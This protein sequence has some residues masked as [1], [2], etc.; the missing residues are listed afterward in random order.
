MIVTK[1]ATF[2]DNRCNARS[3]TTNWQIL[4]RIYTLPI[5]T[6]TLSVLGSLV[7]RHFCLSLCDCTSVVLCISTC[8]FLYICICVCHLVF[9]ANCVIYQLMD[10]KHDDYA[11]SSACCAI[12]YFFTFQRSWWT[13]DQ[14]DFPY[15]HS[16]SRD[17]SV[18]RIENSTYCY[19]VESAVSQL[20]K[21]ST[22]PVHMDELERQAK[23]LI[24]P[25]GSSPITCRSR[26]GVRGFQ[27]AICVMASLL[28]FLASAEGYFQ[29]VEYKGWMVCLAGLFPR[30]RFEPS[31]SRSS[32]RAH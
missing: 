12:E 2:A 20:K 19:V 10:G 25:E 18:V 5:N 9:L 11:L 14:I 17:R 15:L 13:A 28:P 24:K 21:K 32:I 1:F 8:V 22:L 30:V 7:R 16:L 31:T 27:W 29:F 26:G 3:N 23:G 6:Y 4:C